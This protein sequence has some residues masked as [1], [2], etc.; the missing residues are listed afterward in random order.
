MK[1]GTIQSVAQRLDDCSPEMARAI[2]LLWVHP[3]W[4]KEITNEAIKTL[5]GLLNNAAVEALNE[6]T[7]PKQYIRGDQGNQL[8]LEM[9]ICT[10]DDRRNFQV[11]ALLDSGCTG[12]KKSDQHQ[13]APSTHSGIQCRWHQELRRRYH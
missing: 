12:T 7:L 1:P 11:K 9:T 6:L 10:L 8:D 4:R 5:K 2:L 3:K 13:E